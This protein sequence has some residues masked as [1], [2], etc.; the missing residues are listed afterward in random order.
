MLSPAA[1]SALREA[2]ATLGK[3][4][5]RLPPALD[6]GPEPQGA[7]D[8]IEAAAT[9]LREVLRQESPVTVEVQPGALACGGEAV[10]TDPPREAGLAQ[11]LYRDGIRSLSFHRGLQP[12]ELLVLCRAALPEPPAGPGRDD[13]ITELWRAD[14]PFLS[15]TAPGAYALEHEGFGV[16][17]VSMAINK[18][19]ARARPLVEAALRQGPADAAPA[20]GQPLL[21]EEQ[22]AALDPQSWPELARRSTLA[23]LQIVEQGFAGG[24]LERLEEMYWRLLDALVARRELGPLT[25]ALEGLRKV[26]G[27]VGPAFRAAVGERMA[28]PARL[29]RAAELAALGQTALSH[30][31]PSWLSLLPQAAGGALLEVLPRVPPLA[32][33]LFARGVIDR[34]D[35]ALERLGT[36]LTKGPPP[37]ALALLGALDGLSPFTRAEFAAPALQHPSSRV[38]IEAAGAVGGEPELALQLL[39]PLLQAQEASVRSG[40]A[41]VLGGCGGV[42]EGAAALLVAAMEQGAFDGRDREEKTTFHRALGRLA[43]ETGFQ[44]LSTRLLGARERS[45]FRLRRSDSEEDRVLAALGL[46]EDPSL[47]ASRALEAALEQP[48]Q[49]AVVLQAARSALQ[50]RQALWH[51]AA[52]GKGAS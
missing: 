24:D 38:R 26:A 39:G 50:R 31:L 34:A 45:V 44:F 47:R 10:Y 12:A 19:T 2:L 42:A 25:V 21:S 11:R 13:A 5:L 43:C 22:L 29:Q 52:H 51:T 14:L 32:Q 6:A 41:L 48:G 27:V 9:A 7:L 37:V 3:A 1:T 46:S 33:P 18:I 23:L 40:V 8:A 30:V 15:F 35:A 16:T 28:E 20:E 36:A 49:P 4:L 17:A